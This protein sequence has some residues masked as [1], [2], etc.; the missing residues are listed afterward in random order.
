MNDKRTASRHRVF[1][2]GKIAFDGGVIDCTVRNLSK[3]GAALEVESPV[4][5]PHKF[6]V[7]IESDRIRRGCHVVW[8]KERRIGVMFH[9]DPEN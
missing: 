9:N 6:T 2:A 1:K 5:I 7:V 8:R 4:G 3:T